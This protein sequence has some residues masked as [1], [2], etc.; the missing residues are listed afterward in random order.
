[1]TDAVY[2]E[3]IASRPVLRREFRVFLA[4]SDC[5]AS[6]GALKW[7]G[8]FL[9]RGVSIRSAKEKRH[10]VNEC[11]SRTRCK[12]NT[13]YVCMYVCMY[14]LITLQWTKGY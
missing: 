7:G 10:I 1:M 6:T 13:V 3:R 9:K 14:I 8:R 2:S 4:A 11:K 12:E 5:V